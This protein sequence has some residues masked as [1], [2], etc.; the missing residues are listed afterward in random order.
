MFGSAPML[1]QVPLRMGQN[2]PSP[3]PS[4]GPTQ[5]V[6]P[7]TV[8]FAPSEQFF[9]FPYYYPQYYP[10]HERPTRLIC[11]RTEDEDGEEIF[12]CEERRDVTY[13]PPAPQY[14]VYPV[15]RYWF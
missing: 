11:R 7:Q 12:E 4:P 8:G 3:S 13:Y 15:F 2:G 14:P 5:S 9:F 10:Q 6:T 1:P